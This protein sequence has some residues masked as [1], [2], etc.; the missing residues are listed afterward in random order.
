VTFEI[1]SGLEHS[2]DGDPKGED[3]LP[4]LKRG[5][6]WCVGVEEE[7]KCRSG[8]LTSIRGS[9]TAP[10]GSEKKSK[11]MFSFFQCFSQLARPL[12]LGS[13]ATTSLHQRLLTSPLPSFDDVEEPWHGHTRMYTE[14]FR[15]TFSF[16][17]G[18]QCC[19][20]TEYLHSISETS[21]SASA[22]KKGGLSSLFSMLLS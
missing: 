15:W 10:L 14:H 11:V 9:S 13:N 3:Y 1:K 12:S 19:C 2:V 8:R 5:R 6:F 21:L 7:R 16:L 18:G 4:L 17:E 20:C 22:K